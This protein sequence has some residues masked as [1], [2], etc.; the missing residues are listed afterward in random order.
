MQTKQIIVISDSRWIGNLRWTVRRTKQ[1]QTYRLSQSHREHY[2]KCRQ[3][4]K[5][6]ADCATKHTES[7]KSNRIAKKPILL[8]RTPGAAEFRSTLTP[9]DPSECHLALN[10]PKVLSS[11]S[12]SPERCINPPKQS[13][14]KSSLHGTSEQFVGDYQVGVICGLLDRPKMGRPRLMVRKEEKMGLGVVYFG[15]SRF[16]WNFN[17]SCP[18]LLIRFMTKP[19]ITIQSAVLLQLRTTSLFFVMLRDVPIAMTPGIL[20]GPQR[21]PILLMR[22]GNVL[23][24]F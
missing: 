12:L 11:R 17:H 18:F 22:M 21:F 19:S 16:L 14:S 2:Q 1:L 6:R 3:W 10:F 24:G 15:F 7:M 20:I 4:Q 23:D 5:L 9:Q 13:K 8:V